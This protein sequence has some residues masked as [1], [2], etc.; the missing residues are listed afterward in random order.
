MSLVSKYKYVNMCS[1]FPRFIEKTKWV[2]F[3]IL[4]LCCIQIGAA[5]LPFS[6]QHAFFHSCPYPHI[7]RDTTIIPPSLTLSLSP[8]LP[9]SLSALWRFLVIS[10]TIWRPR[11]TC[12][13]VHRHMTGS[14]L[15]LFALVLACH[16]EGWVGMKSVCRTCFCLDI[17]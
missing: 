4:E 6:L 13:Y 14:R 2:Y 5:C 1:I 10:K 7:N 3:T 11:Y 15:I 16:F 12:T 8:F 17:N 9:I